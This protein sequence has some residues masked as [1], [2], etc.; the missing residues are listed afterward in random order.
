M[1]TLNELIEAA[2]LGFSVKFTSDVMK[3]AAENVIKE[4]QKVAVTSCQHLITT[5][6]HNL[7]EQVKHLQELR[8]KEAKQQAKVKK[9]DRAFKFFAETGN[10]L[11][12]FASMGK[13]PEGEAWARQLGLNHNDEAAWTIDDAWQPKQ[14][15]QQK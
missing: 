10:P 12:F 3:E 6:D 8:E 11:P 1:K 4:K 2:H 15:E 14:E 5:F 13:Q 9:I 7:K